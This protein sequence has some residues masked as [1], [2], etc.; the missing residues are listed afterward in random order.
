VA[1][2]RTAFPTGFGAE[3]RQPWVRPSAAVVTNPAALLGRRRV[4]YAAVKRG[5]DLIVAATLLVVLLPLFALLSLAIVLDSGLPVFYR[6]DRI[7]RLGQRFT[8]LKFRSMHAACDESAHIAFVRSVL[9]EANHYQIYKVPDDRR[10][11]RV[12]T[13]LR[14]TSLD[15]LPQLWNVLRGEMS[16]VGPR[17]D[18]PYAVDQYADWMH[19]RLLVKPGITGLWQVSGRSRLSLLDMYRLDLSYAAR[20]SL[21]VDF[22]IL[23]RTVPAVLGGDGAA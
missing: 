14:R 2:E 7:G 18:V 4:A 9:R 8:M 22:E 20:A 15:E 21:L 17:P 11:T 3:A 23:V 10:I 6:G 19:H 13:F 1:A 5:V 12:G 16:L